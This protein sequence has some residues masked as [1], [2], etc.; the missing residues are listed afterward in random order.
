VCIMVLGRP[1]DHYKLLSWICAAIV[2]ANPGSVAFCEVEGSRFIRM[3][4]AYAANVN[5]F[6]L[7]CRKILFMDGCH[8]SRPYKGTLLAACGL[9]ADNHLFN[10]AYGIVCG[11]VIE[12]WVWFLQ[13]V[14]ECLGGLKP[15][16]MSDKNP[17]LLAT[18]A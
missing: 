5:G 8:L 1:D 11:E 14:M 17:A 12:K 18:V 6:K 9:D 16:I 7:G 15:I 3:F 13:T 2:R 4:I 10:F